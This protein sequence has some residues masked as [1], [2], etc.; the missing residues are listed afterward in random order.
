MAGVVLADAFWWGELEGVDGGVEVVAAHVAEFADAVVAPGAPVHGVVGLV[1][2]GGWVA[3]A[4]PFVPVE[5]AWGG[6]CGWFEGGV[7]GPPAEG[8]VFPEDDFF[9]F[10]DGAVA[11]EFDHHAA[12]DAAAALVAHLGDD[13]CFFGFGEDDAAFMDGGGHGFLQVD[14]FF[15]S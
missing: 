1:E 11:E 2:E 12:F 4:E 5:G 6:V 3:D 15:F 10:A 14:V 13:A 9:D 8:F 7:F